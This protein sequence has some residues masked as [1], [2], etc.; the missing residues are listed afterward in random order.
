MID[1]REI[2]VRVI[3]LSDEK[4]ATAKSNLN[5]VCN[6]ADIKRWNGIRGKDLFEEDNL[7]LRSDHRDIIEQKYPHVSLPVHWLSTQAQL[8]LQTNKTNVFDMHNPGA[9]GC[10]LSHISLWQHMVATGMP[11]MFVCEDDI[12]FKDF[13]LTKKR[14]FTQELNSILSTFHTD[15]DVLNL[16][17]LFIPNPIQ[18]ATKTVQSKH[19]D[20]VFV[21]GFAGRCQGYLIT[22]HGARFLL[23]NAFPLLHIVDAYMTIFSKMRQYSKEYVYL[24]TKNSW[25][26]HELVNLTT[27]AIGYDL[28]QCATDAIFLIPPTFLLSLIGFFVISMIAMFILVVVNYRLK[29]RLLLVKQNNL[30]KRI[31]K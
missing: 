7:I 3:A 13:F 9:V 26:E 8:A 29:N 2:P 12:E 19:K 21:H 30:A 5:R 4:F 28:G 31:K 10:A 11:I 6:F 16:N 1:C 25:L 14:S 22:Q 20:V 15:F 23:Q 17:A 18:F 24:A 27:S